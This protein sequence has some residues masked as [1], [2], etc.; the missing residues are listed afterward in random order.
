MGALCWHAIR[1]E[2]YLEGL[3]QIQGSR[4]W[5]AFCADPASAGW[6]AVL[7]FRAEQLHALPSAAGGSVR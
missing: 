7:A 1:T 4:D 5:T 2:P 6:L 3:D